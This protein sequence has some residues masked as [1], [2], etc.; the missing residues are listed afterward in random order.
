MMA[1][2]LHR[3]VARL[4]R[5]QRGTAARPVAATGQQSRT[6]GE[7]SIRCCHP[8]FESGWLTANG[9]SFVPQALR[10][11]ATRYSSLVSRGARTVNILVTGGCG[12]IGANFI[13]YLLQQP[14]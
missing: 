1:A 2:V 10:R 7:W 11:L 13:R 8:A 4:C 14:A 12:F 9:S 5:P 3:P 6:P